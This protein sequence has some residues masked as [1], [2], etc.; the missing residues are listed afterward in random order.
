MFTDASLE[1]WAATIINEQ[2]LK[3]SIFFGSWLD[4]KHEN[5]HS[6]PHINVLESMAFLLGCQR[7]PC[8]SPNGEIIIFIDNTTVVASIEKQYSANFRTNETTRTA[9]QVLAEKGYVAHRVRWVDSIRNLADHFTRM[10][11]FRVHEKTGI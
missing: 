11:A 7:L 3:V 4:E 2:P 6:I 8:A 1:G 5:P 10:S 9:L